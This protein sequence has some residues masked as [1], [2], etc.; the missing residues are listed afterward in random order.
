LDIVIIKIIVIIS[1]SCCLLS[2]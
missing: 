2:S 1:L